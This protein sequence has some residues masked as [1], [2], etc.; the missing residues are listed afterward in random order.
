[1][2]QSFLNDR[3]AQKLIPER[4]SEIERITNLI[5]QLKMKLKEDKDRR[6]S[7]AYRRMKTRRRED[8]I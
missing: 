5:G 8:A 6:E 4:D 1:M 2:I 3:A 7:L